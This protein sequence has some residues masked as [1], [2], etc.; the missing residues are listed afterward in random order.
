MPEELDY[1]AL[2]QRIKKYRLQKHYTQ[3]KLA[4]LANCA[5]SSVSHAERGTSQPS[6]Q[7][8]V[9]FCN[10]LDITVDQLLCDSLPIAQNTLEKDISELLK[11]MFSTGIE[12]HKGY[13]CCNK[14]NIT[15]KQVATGGNSSGCSSHIASSPY[16][17]R[18]R[19]HKSSH[20]ACISSDVCCGKSISG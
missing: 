6:L 4:E 20:P 7:L 2:G 10:I 9:R 1:K 15:G 12:N 14:E 19:L 11:W 3:E 17:S 8:L 18:I 16:L 13:Y 5:I